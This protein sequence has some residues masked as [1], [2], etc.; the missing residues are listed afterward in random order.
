MTTDDEG[1]ET[2]REQDDYVEYLHKDHL[3]SVEGATDEA[4]ARTRT[5]AHDPFGE[6][7]KADWTAALTDAERAAL[8]G[9][10]DPR[11]RGH[12]GHEHLDR[13]GFIHRGGRV[14]DPTLGRFLS[15]DPLV[16][17]PGSAQAWNGYSYVS[18]SPMS[19]VD[20]S[21]LSQAPGAGGC[22]L[23]GVMCGAAGGGFGLASVVSTHRF[24][25]VDIFIS[26]VSS[27]FN[28]PTEPWINYRGGGGAAD[29]GWGSYDSR[30][31]FSFGIAIFSAT[32]Q[33]TS[34]V[35]VAG[36]LDITRRPMESSSGYDDRLD[37]QALGPVAPLLGLLIREAARRAIP[38]IAKKWIRYKQ[39]NK[40]KEAP[41]R[42]NQ[43]PILSE[44]SIESVEDVFSNP[45]LLEGR[46]PEQVI[47]EIGNT[48][49]WIQDVM[50]HSESHPG[51][52]WVL[53]ELN[54]RGD[55]FTHRMIQYHPG[56]WRHFNGKPY[57]KISGI[58]N[59]G[60]VRVVAAP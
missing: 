28:R 33:V 30:D 11:T 20:P 18:N 54:R 4:G 41:S 23:V 36:V 26:F 40:E 37:Q 22:D 25:Y 53:R 59:K 13:T 57:W 58:P 12:T 32:F 15:P 9:S 3:G 24:L 8:A 10:S 29:G 46:S 19:F 39:R 44:G 55:D 14:Y 50:R 35:A 34:Q 45:S 31:A 48:P 7:R 17:N 49:G 5:L 21:G 42:A 38:W 1:N 2:G 43:Q 51:G 52:G 47:S 56:S 16:G 6:R 60:S 27:W